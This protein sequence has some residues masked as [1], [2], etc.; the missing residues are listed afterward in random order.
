M[1]CLSLSI[2]P[3]EQD[4]ALGTHFHVHAMPS[5]N[6]RYRV[7]KAPPQLANAC[8]TALEGERTGHG[9]GLIDC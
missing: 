2:P 5:L 6:H 9:G 8:A 3:N 7:F 4:G 1:R